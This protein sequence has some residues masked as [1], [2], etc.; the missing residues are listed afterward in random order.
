MSKL[1][2]VVG[3][4]KQAVFSENK[5]SIEYEN[6]LI[7][8]LEQVELLREEHPG[9]GLEKMYY[10]LQPDFLGRDAFIEIFMDLGFRVRRAKNFKRTT[11]SSDKFYKNLINGLVLKG[12]G[13]VWQTDITYIYVGD[14]F[15]YATYII[16]VYTRVIVGYNISKSL[17]VESNIKALEMAVTEYGYP[18]IHHS[19]RGSQY[20]CNEYIALLKTNK[21]KISMGKCAQENAY[22]ERINLTIKDEYLRYRT[23]TTFEK[24]VNENSRSVKNYNEKRLHENLGMKPPLKF[25][26]ELQNKRLKKPVMQIHDYSKHPNYKK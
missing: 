4:S 13:H 18:K 15:Y 9:C 2:K 6:K 17:R 8:L 16:D 5:K 12:F 10:T 23:M 3:I 1:Y 11:Y 25:L 14:K 21:T 19:D 20:N 22:A 26:E 24:L 7:A